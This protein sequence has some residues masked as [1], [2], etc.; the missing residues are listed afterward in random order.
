LD[1]EQRVPQR[2]RSVLWCCC[3]DAPCLSCHAVG[4]VV[5]STSVPAAYVPVAS[6][7]CPG[8]RRHDVGARH[9]LAVAGTGGPVHVRGALWQG[10]RYV[11]RGRGA[12]GRWRAR[13]HASAGVSER[14]RGRRGGA[15]SGGCVTPRVKLPARG[16]LN[17]SMPRRIA[18]LAPDVAPPSLHCG[19]MRLS[20]CVRC[21]EVHRLFSDSRRV[22][23]CVCARVFHRVCVCV[24]ACVC[25][26]S[27]FEA[28]GDVPVVP[29]RPRGRRHDAAGAAAARHARF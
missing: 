10:E 8:T 20:V 23:L 7:R 14:A 29:Q 25:V 11:F 17:L 6:Q 24:C 2:P 15:V 13:R 16:R 12:A 4:T 28:C 18:H 26:S 19:Q 3:G 27:G 5:C 9:S 22:R 21:P 1:E